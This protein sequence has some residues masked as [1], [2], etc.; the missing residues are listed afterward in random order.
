MEYNRYPIQIQL[1]SIQ[2]WEVG[3]AQDP[4]K[5]KTGYQIKFDRQDYFLS[6]LLCTDFSF[7]L[8]N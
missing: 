6:H 3:K 5:E 2:L 8:A 4:R 1:R 7:Q